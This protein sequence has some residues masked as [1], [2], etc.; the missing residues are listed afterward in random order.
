[1]RRITRSDI[2]RST[3]EPFRGT[4][5]TDRFEPRVWTPELLAA[6]RHSVETTDR[7]L[8]AIAKAHAIPRSTFYS[9]VRRE[10]WHRPGAD[11]HAEPARASAQP[12][13]R[14]TSRPR[15]RKKARRPR[16]CRAPAA[17]REPTASPPP[18]S[19]VAP[20]STSDLAERLER[21]VAREIAALEA[22]RS[23][24][25]EP[26]GT[27]RKSTAQRSA[28]SDT[29][30]VVRS[31]ERLTDTLAK[32]RRLR[33]PVPSDPDDDLPRDIDE[34]R[35]VLARRIEQ[36]VRGGADRDDAGGPA[37]DGAAEARG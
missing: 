34:F 37:G 1:M 2:D 21:A 36:L 27:V 13:A 5:M 9:L 25:P 31:L 19:L 3:S 23:A 14:K 16:S 28:A 32:V 11:P 7:A 17:A 6:L 26:A 10:G 8:S 35:R 12:C 30:R 20:P 15:A 18:P 22:S 4:A 33:E 29:E 24:P